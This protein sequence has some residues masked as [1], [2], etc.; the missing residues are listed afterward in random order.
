VEEVMISISIPMLSPAQLGALK[1]I[2]SP[3]V[4]N[5]IEAF[6]VRDPTEGYASFELRCLFPDLPPA[7]GYAITCTADSISPDKSRPDQSKAFYK[8]IR[9]APKPAVVVMK[10][11]G[12][13]RSR[14]CHAGDVMCTIFQTLGAIALVTDGGV[15]DL[16]G[17]RQRA[18]GFSLFAPGVMVSHGVATIVEVGVPVSVCGLTIRPGDL[19]HADLNGLVT[20][21]LAIADRVAAQAKKVWENEQAIID[22][23]KSPGFTLEAYGEKYGW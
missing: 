12:S 21:P 7:V 4:S 3:T 10:D 19:V 2:D 13:D 11:V 9:A 15:R 23:V 1:V 22:F 14:S 8:A 17:I 5:A 20:I 16:A 18:P 6:E